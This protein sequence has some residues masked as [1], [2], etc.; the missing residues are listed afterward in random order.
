MAAGAAM[1]L[2]A[3]LPTAPETLAGIVIGAVVVACVVPVLY[4]WW[5]WHSQRRV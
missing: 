1:T 2:A 4:S 3:A 5:H